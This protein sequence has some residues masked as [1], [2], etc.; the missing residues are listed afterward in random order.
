MWSYDFIHIG[1]FGLYYRDCFFTASMYVWRNVT[2]VRMERRKPLKTSKQNTQL[3]QMKQGFFV[4]DY[5]HSRLYCTTMILKTIIDSITKDY[6]PFV[7]NL[8]SRFAVILQKVLPIQ[9]PAE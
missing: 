1:P 9:R 2:K 7:L 8:Y 3:T 4:F 5:F 6:Q